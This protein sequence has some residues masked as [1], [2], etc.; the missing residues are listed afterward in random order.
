MR[1]KRIAII[2]T[3]ACNGGD[4]AILSAIV[5]QVRTVWPR[6]VITAYDSQADAAARYHDWI[7]FDYSAYR[8]ASRE[9]GVAWIRRTRWLCGAWLRGCGWPRAGAA[10]AHA[11]DRR[12]LARLARS[13][14]VIST[15]GT[16]LV[17]T[18]GLRPR[19]FEFLAVRL[20]RR[21]TVLYTQTMGPFRRRFNR[22]GMRPVLRAARLVF[23]RDD[24]S[25]A[26]ALGLG[27]APASTHVVPDVVFGA[28]DEQS[29]TRLAAAHIDQEPRLCIS[30]RDLKPFTRADPAAS[31]RYERAV[32]R[33]AAHLVRERGATIDFLSSCQGIPEYRFDD[34]AVAARIVA[35]LPDD[36]RGDVRV[37]EGFHTPD[38]LMTMY[39]G[40]DAVIATRMHVAILA[41]S[42]G[43]PVLPIPYE[44]K[45]DE[46]FRDLAAPFPIV[47]AT[48]ADGDALIV[49]WEAFEEKLPEWRST[50][51]SRLARWRTEARWPAQQLALLVE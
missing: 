1:A 31:S 35:Q 33:L 20:L 40:Y 44:R 21:P 48:A 17:E 9:R 26:I 22:S 49:S 3:V 8:A 15:G 42:A 23:V 28:A 10:T 14:V 51:A 30:V 37:V 34:A 24:A 43:T 6:C 46:L 11:A 7:S 50:A 41:L 2:N 13:D 18:Y 29:A 5:E 39:A 27:A 45:I 47:P 19:F 38:E 12:R 32:A 25:R 36:M 16:Y 4:A